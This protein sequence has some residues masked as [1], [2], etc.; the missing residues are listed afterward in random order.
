MPPNVYAD[1]E[2]VEYMRQEMAK[3]RTEQELDAPI[4]IRTASAKM[5]WHPRLNNP[6][7]ARWLHRIDVPTHLIRAIP[8]ASFHPSTAMPTRS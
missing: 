7:L 1:P 6:Q 5:C 2:F 4:R 8:T 3:P